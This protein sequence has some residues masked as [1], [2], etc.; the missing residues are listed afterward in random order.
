MGIVDK[1]R[2]QAASLDRVLLL[3]KIIT[4]SLYIGI[5]LVAPIL[6]Y[7]RKWFNFQFQVNLTFS[8][9]QSMLELK[10]TLNIYFTKLSP[11]SKLMLTRFSHFVHVLLLLVENM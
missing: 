1:H 2:K 5:A 11:M 9:V 7:I 3:T 10:C 6:Q 4:R 8:T